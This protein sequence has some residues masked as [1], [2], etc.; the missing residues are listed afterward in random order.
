VLRAA[1]NAL[2]VVTYE[3]AATDWS[4]VVNSFRDSGKR[5]SMLMQ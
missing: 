5:I 4:L 3:V 2:L 1:A